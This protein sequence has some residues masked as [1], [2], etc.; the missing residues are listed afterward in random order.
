MSMNEID[1]IIKGLDCCKNG[2]LCGK[3]PYNNGD[4]KN[5]TSSLAIDVLNL[6]HKQA[7]VKT[8]EEVCESTF[9]LMEFQDVIFPCLV[10]TDIYCNDVRMT[11]ETGSRYMEKDEY[12]KTWRCWSAMPT[13]EQRESTEWDNDF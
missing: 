4:I 9:A 13:P 6:I 12:G 11:D 1:K 10:K 3:C 2:T 5:C 8:L 7:T